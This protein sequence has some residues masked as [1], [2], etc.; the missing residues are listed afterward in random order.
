[1]SSTERNEM[2]IE[3]AILEAYDRIAD[4]LTVIM[5]TAVVIGAVQFVRLVVA[6]R[7]NHYRR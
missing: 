2:G 6:I 7:D 5:Y 4:A 3:I 1:M